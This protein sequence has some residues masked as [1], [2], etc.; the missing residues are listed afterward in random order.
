MTTADQYTFA[1]VA[2]LIILAFGLL[3]AVMRSLRLLERE[4]QRTHNLVGQR[5]RAAQLVAQWRARAS[6]VEDQLQRQSIPDPVD[7]AFARTPA[8]ND[9]TQQIHAL[10]GRGDA[11]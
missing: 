9:V 7:R 11:T 5:D 2:A 4:R 6:R 3:G 8:A 1:A 10:N